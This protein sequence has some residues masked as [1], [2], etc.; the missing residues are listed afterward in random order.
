M[1]KRN[2]W[3]NVEAHDGFTYYDLDDTAT[4]ERTKRRPKRRIDK[5]LWYNQPK[6][7]KERNKWYKKLE[8]A[9]FKDIEFA[10]THSGDVS[11]QFRVSSPDRMLMTNYS[12]VEYFA[13]TEYFELLRD[14]VRALEAGIDELGLDPA[15]I[16]ELRIM[17]GVEF[18]QSQKSLAKEVGLTAP[19][20]SVIVAKHVKRAMRSVKTTESANVE[21][22][23]A[24][25][26]GGVCG[27]RDERSQPV[28]GS[29]QDAGPG[30]VQEVCNR[31]RCVR[32]ASRR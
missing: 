2:T 22:R 17:Q 13:K 29:N 11:D 3:P 14:Y 5:E 18:G 21:E 20:V 24:T 23:A 8:K 25:D 10:L 31:G 9:G 27:G 7:L 30:E 28:A 16:L 4:R 32:G 12:P 1:S 15:R 26:T 19:V 6:F